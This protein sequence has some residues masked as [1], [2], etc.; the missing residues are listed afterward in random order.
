MR[1]LLISQLCLSFLVNCTQALA[2]GP[3]HTTIVTQPSAVTIVPF[4]IPVAVP[5]ATIASPTVFYSYQH[6]ARSYT[7]TTSPP[8][9]A[10][11]EPSSTA[12]TSRPSSPLDPQTMLTR[13]CAECHLAPAAQGVLTLFSADGQVAPKLPRHLVL[14]AVVPD[15]SHQVAMPPASRPRLSVEESRALRKWATLSRDV[16][17]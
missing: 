9:L 17:F 10:S 2:G 8:T 15:E 7:S 12:P 16:L 3:C 5:V 6:Q 11:Q 1:T 14:T 13:H 4:A